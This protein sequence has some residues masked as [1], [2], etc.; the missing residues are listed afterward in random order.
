MRLPNPSTALSEGTDSCLK[1]G[2]FHNSSLCC[3]GPKCRRD[4][5]DEVSRLG[6]VLFPQKCVRD[7]GRWQECEAGSKRS[8]SAE[9]QAGL[10]LSWE[11]V[12][13]QKHCLRVGRV[14]L[15]NSRDDT[16]SG[17]YTSLPLGLNLSYGIPLSSIPCKFMQS[18]GHRG[19]KPYGFK[20]WE[21]CLCR[22][23]NTVCLNTTAKGC[24]GSE[25][26]YH[27]WKWLKVPSALQNFSP[28]K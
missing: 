16:E 17:E 15:V 12:K 18:M 7:A 21:R 2:S 25:A 3:R 1:T 9:L 22:L 8:S 26:R 10:W 5:F 19:T 24:L 14:F 11:A 13:V 23:S 28:Q 20:K 4:G 27:P 6:S